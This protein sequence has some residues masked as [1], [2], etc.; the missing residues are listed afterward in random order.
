MTRILICPVAGDVNF[1]GSKKKC[2]N[3]TCNQ[4]G[5]FVWKT[6]MSKKYEIIHEV[7]RR[8][9]GDHMGLDCPREQSRA[10]WPHDVLAHGTSGR[11]M[12]GQSRSPTAKTGNAR[13][14]GRR[15]A[16][17]FGLEGHH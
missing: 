1:I 9:L 10:W 14:R 2:V 15:V 17:P 7:E 4:K 5:S 13:G 11:G 8:L 12:G 16:S 3:G 6:E